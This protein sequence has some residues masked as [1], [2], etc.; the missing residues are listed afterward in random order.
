M[1]QQKQK[2]KIRPFVAYACDRYNKYKVL[3]GV[4]KADIGKYMTKIRKDKVF[5]FKHYWIPT[6]LFNQTHN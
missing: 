3:S 4:K 2:E 1:T 5:A 6:L